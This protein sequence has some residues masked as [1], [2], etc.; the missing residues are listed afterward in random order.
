MRKIVNE[1]MT[2]VLPIKFVVGSKPG[3]K[4]KLDTKTVIKDLKICIWNETWE[5][6]I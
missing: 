2:G 1:M 6:N 4:I 5:G 3:I